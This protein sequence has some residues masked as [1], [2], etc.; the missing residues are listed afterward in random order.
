MK[1]VIIGGGI[2][3]LTLANAFKKFNITYHLFE[4]AEQF[5]QV[6]AGIGLS[7]SALKIFR[8]LGLYDQLI[9]EGALISK[10]V[11]VD[12]NFSKIRSIPVENTGLCIERTR[13]IDLLLSQLNQRK[14]SLNKNLTSLDFHNNST[15]LQ[16]ADGSIIESNCVMA[17]DGIDSSIRHHI[18]PSIIKRYS[19]QTIW[20]GTSD[21]D[22][23]S[24][25][26]DTYYEVW[27]DNL[28]FG[29]CPMSKQKFYWYAVKPSSANIKQDHHEALSTLKYVFRNF[30]SLVI[31][32]I[33]STKQIIK[34]DM[35]D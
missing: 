33:N 15:Q 1:I 19:G 9:T 21:L 2:G 32:L 12:R 22:L 24:S 3:G 29:I 23:P 6:G 30:K 26:T 27:G 7:E 31:D 28:R 14:Y 16:F 5:K 10:S 20:R 17:C 18:Y 34:H 35:W 11:I 4:R 13:L 8:I 25:F